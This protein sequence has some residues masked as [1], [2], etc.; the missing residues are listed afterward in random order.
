MKKRSKKNSIDITEENEHQYWMELRETNNSDIRDALII[1]YLPLVKYIA[2]RIPN[3]NSNKTI[4]FD[5]LVCYGKFGLI[6]AVSKYDPTKG[7]KFNTYALTRIRGQIYD[8]LRTLDPLPRTIRQRSKII[9]ESRRKLET[10]YGRDITQQEIIDD[11]GMSEYD[12]KNTMVYVHRSSP[13]SLNYVCYV[14]DSDEIS[15]EDMVKSTEKVSP[16]Y[17]VEREEIKKIIAGVLNE[18]PDKEKQVLILYYYEE[19]TLKEI[20]AVLEV[21]ESRVSQ[22][23]TKAK[24]AVNYRIREIRKNLL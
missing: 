10:R 6:D 20:G 2:G 4:E 9:E 12:F 18:L 24:Q 1:K 14:D 17:I 11:T 22:L 3:V 21:S 19:L 7:I 8:E 5:D 15:I 13:V 16:D 23:H